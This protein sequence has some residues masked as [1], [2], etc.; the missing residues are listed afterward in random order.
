MRFWTDVTD[1]LR[2]G[3]GRERVVSM[4]TGTWGAVTEWRWGKG[5]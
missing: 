5:E 1:D 4:D 2:K 3:R